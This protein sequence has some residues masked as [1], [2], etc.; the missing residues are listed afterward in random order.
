MREEI[1]KDIKGFEGY[2]VVSN[3]GRVK[4]L[5][6]WGRVKYIKRE[7][8]LKPTRISST[9]NYCFERVTLTRH[10]KRKAERVHRLVANAFIPN[11]LNK[12]EVNHINSNP[13]DNRI[14]NLEWCT[15]K[16][17]SEHAVK[18]GGAGHN[19]SESLIVKEYM[20]GL[21]VNELVVKYKS[22]YKTINNILKKTKTKK[23]SHYIDS[24]RYKVPMN[25]LLKCIEKGEEISVIAQKFNAPRNLISVYKYQF[26]KGVR[27]YQ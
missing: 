24:S 2:Y 25:E 3:K 18:Y 13:L 27:T 7:R 1:W 19:I 11:P 21:K 14:E 22:T 6:G 16:E 10:K 20:S 9:P 17:N 26:K 12:L 5:I 8:I 23:R 15:S 4:S